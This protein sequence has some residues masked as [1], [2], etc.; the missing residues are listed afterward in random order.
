MHEPDPDRVVVQVACLN[1]DSATKLVSEMLG[2]MAKAVGVENDALSGPAESAFGWDFYPLAI[3]RSFVQR[4][5]N[6]PGN[7]IW[8]MK[9]GNLDEKFATWLNRQL[10]LRTESVQ[11]RLLADL[12]SSRFGLF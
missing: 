4:L 8:R 7:D 12:K 9:G 1:Y 6:M 5:A 10:E 3:R 2:N 11:V